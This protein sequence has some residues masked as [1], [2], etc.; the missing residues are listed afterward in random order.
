[1]TTENP[2]NP[3]DGSWVKPDVHPCKEHFKDAMLI[4]TKTMKTWSI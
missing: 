3:D 4:Q 2:T 1:M